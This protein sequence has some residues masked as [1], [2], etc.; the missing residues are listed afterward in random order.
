MLKLWS[1]QSIIFPNFVFGYFHLRRGCFFGLFAGNIIN[2]Q[3]EWQMICLNLTKKFSLTAKKSYFNFR[4]I[5][6]SWLTFKILIHQGPLGNMESSQLPSTGCQVLLQLFT[7]WQCIDT[8]IQQQI[9]Y[10]QQVK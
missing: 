8:T 9:R 10:L 2:N 7:S 3:L 5:H 6:L 4:D 1:H